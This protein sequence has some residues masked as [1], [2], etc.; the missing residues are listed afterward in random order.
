[1]APTTR[2]AVYTALAPNRVED[3]WWEGFAIDVYA[4]VRNVVSYGQDPQS[5]QAGQKN[6]LIDATL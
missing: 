3:F 4:A 2:T 1:M 6:V 5:C